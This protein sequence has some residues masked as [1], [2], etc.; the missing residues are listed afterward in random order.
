MKHISALLIPYR[1]SRSPLA[2]NRVKTA[3]EQE[4]FGISGAAGASAN[5]CHVKRKIPLNYFCSRARPLHE[6][7][8]V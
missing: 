8:P 6:R 7:R 1:R 3:G 5:L 4:G 2:T